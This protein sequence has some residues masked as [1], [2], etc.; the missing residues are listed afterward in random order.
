MIVFCTIHASQN[1]RN[2]RAAENLDGSQM[3]WMNIEPSLVCKRVLQELSFPGPS[4]SHCAHQTLK[5]GVCWLRRRPCCSLDLVRRAP[6]AG[7]E[8]CLDHVIFSSYLPHVDAEVHNNTANT[9][10]RLEDGHIV[11]VK[12][13]IEVKRLLKGLPG[14]LKPMVARGKRNISDNDETPL[15]GVDHSLGLAMTW[16]TKETV[17]ARSEP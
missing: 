9:A 11:T 1:P 6:A 7:G 13:R 2:E 8:A 14:L 3:S 15:V 5:H 4:R 10:T 17:C 16:I 12:F